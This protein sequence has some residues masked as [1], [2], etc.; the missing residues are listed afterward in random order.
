MPFRSR[1]L[2]LLATAVIGLV[3]CGGGGGGSDAPTSHALSGTITV[4]PTAA[5]DS[6]SNDV[7]QLQQGRYSINDDRASAQPISAPVLLA[8]TV[9]E[10][11][12]GSAGN[13]FDSGDIDDVFI[14][15][16]VADQVVELEFAADPAVSDVDL[17]VL[18]EDEVHA[19]LSEGADTRYE[20]VRVT[21]TARYFIDV[22]AFRGASI[23]N[24]RIAAPGSAT[25]C[26]ASTTAVPAAAGQL[27]AKA[28]RIDGATAQ[29][30]AT[31]M[32]SA[33]LSGAMLADTKSAA[34]VPHVLQLPASATTRRAGLQVLAGR[35]AVKAL[36]ARPA[37][38]AA[39]AGSGL[40]RLD[41]FKYAKQLRATGAFEYV[42][43]NWLNERSAIVGTF[44]PN[45][46]AYSYQRWHYEQINLPAAMSRIN[47]LAAQ[48]AQ[49][50][51]VAVIDDGVVI[52]HPDLAPQLVPGRAFISNTPGDGN[53]PS[54][55]NISRPADNPAFHG[56]HVAGT[57]GAATFD[58]IG[59]AGTAPMA[60]IMPLRVFPRSGGASSLDIIN[61]ML[62]AAGLPNNSGTLPAR[63]ADVINMS[64]GG[65][66]A[67]DAAY[68]GTID[69]VRA[70]GVIVVVAAGNSGHNDRGQRAAVGAPAN[71]NGAIAVSALDAQKGIT[72][73][74]NTGLQ[75]RVA[76]PGGDASKSTTGTGAPDNIYSD[77]ATFDDAG[78]RQPAFGGMQGTSMASPHVAGVM[79]LMRYV[80]PALTPVDI[81][82]L[83]AAGALTDD[84]GS[85]GRDIDFGW[86][87]I[88]ANKA[89]NAA[90]AAGTN[91]PPV[92]AGQVVAAPSSI[93]L[94][95]FQSSAALDLVATGAT[96]ERVAS[97]T[98]DNTN[99]SVAAT[100]IDPTTKLGRYTVSVNRAALAAG[101]I[102]P[103]LT[104]TLTPARSFTVQLTVTKSA[105]GG[106][107]AQGDYGPIYVLVVDPATQQVVDSV[108][109]QRSAGRYTWRAEGVK[110]SKVSVVAGGDLDN[111]DVVCQRG[112]ACGAYPVLAPG[113]DLSVIE[114]STDR[115]DIDFQVAPLSGMSVLR[116]GSSPVAGWRRRV[117]A[118]R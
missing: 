17:Y 95:S 38:A 42:Q 25:S 14:V 76:A 88:N 34:P 113:S 16:L 109:A 33:G 85:S 24:L 3:A 81:D 111:D 18:S 104:V 116:A 37:A 97:V 79:A 35:S 105:G 28:R 70:A 26:Q 100:T 108:V 87:L 5:V 10:P 23:Y 11:G 4:A 101:T 22:R 27:L 56:T 69:Q 48:P 55:D 36:A 112:E 53:G 49:R 54:G 61:A 1:H 9:N 118:G 103:K 50:P 40:D 66:R 73:Y 98:S 30:L 32:R 115:S 43:P 15:D 6:D 2:A 74:S 93:D 58:G 65:D 21:A 80:N 99:V 102:Y 44:P 107:T 13:N 7:N 78:N 47:G 110:L 60:Q 84:L 46:R 8:G 82:N 117:G 39:T 75:I 19:G 41:L 91:P 86:G 57:V 63:K 114:L 68:Q 94:G 52:D 62:Y 64:L 106:T 45:D 77:V 83:F 12:S 59:G 89:V 72:P 90:L 31:R 71:C 67:C 96:A 92:P 29:T 51:I 20:C